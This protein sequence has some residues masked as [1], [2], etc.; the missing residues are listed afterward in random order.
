[1]KTIV[2]D[3]EMNEFAHKLKEN[4]FTVIH[5]DKITTWFF[6]WK[7][8]RM[9]YIQEALLGS[10]F[11]FSAVYHPSKGYGS[12]MRYLSETLELNLENA[13]NTLKFG[14]YQ[15]VD[16][17]PKHYDSAEEYIKKETILKYQIL[18]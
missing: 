3:K 11:D 2:R 9:G 10:G 1:M 7:D 8:G 18:D 14:F 17:S 5:I 13:E 12:S 15:F 6:F 4:G 16:F